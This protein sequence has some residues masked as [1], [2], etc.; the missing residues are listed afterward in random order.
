VAV[1]AGFLMSMKLAAHAA[2]GEG[3]A[4]YLLGRR[5]C[6]L[7]L[8][9]MTAGAATS[10]PRFVAAESTQ[11]RRASLTG[12]AVATSGAL[13]AVLLLASMAIPRS[14]AQLLFGSAE[15]AGLVLGVAVLVGG[16]TL[17][18]LA[19]GYLRGVLHVG[20]ANLL[21][22]ANLALLPIVTLL[23]ATTVPAAFLSLGGLTA[24]SS[25]MALWLGGA[26]VQWPTRRVAWTLLRY[27][28]SRVPGD[29]ALMALFALPPA[30]ATHLTDF[31]QAG[32]VALGSSLVVTLGSLAAPLGVVLLPQA[33]RLVAAGR[34][35]EL[36]TL[37][38]RLLFASLAT[39]ALGTLAFKAIAARVVE[40]YLGGAHLGAV[41]F[42]RLAALGATPYA[43]F[44]LVRSVLDAV[45][46]RP[47]STLFTTLALA[48]CGVAT[49]IAFV[50][51]SVWTLVAANLAGLL[52]LALCSLVAVRP[53]LSRPREQEIPR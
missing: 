45:T 28:G 16:Q 32:Y 19:Y 44:L 36:R 50:T 20:A 8:P 24:A 38:G 25:V 11:A 6:S 1:L 22:T 27:G 42:V 33:S 18:V 3:L 39:A 7:A 47:L 13:V 40:L 52:C 34:S 41:P 14:I 31:R 26:R 49:T 43:A 48:V 35:D 37:A 51:R 46:E 12:A 9:V 29:F 2:L 17:H 15:R 10:L 53:L 4:E 5:L 21:Q 30:V 23:T